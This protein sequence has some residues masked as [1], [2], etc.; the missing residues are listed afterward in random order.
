VRFQ[1]QYRK[2]KASTLKMFSV[3]LSQLYT[4]HDKS[5]LWYEVGHNN[6][7]ERHKERKR[8]IWD[9]M[10]VKKEGGRK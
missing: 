9:M 2:G 5:Q 8:T 3:H 1:F 10:K 4:E 6:K 7:K